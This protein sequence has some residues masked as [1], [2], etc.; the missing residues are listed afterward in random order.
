LLIDNTATAHLPGP[1]NPGVCHLYL[2]EECHLYIALTYECHGSGVLENH[3][4]KTD[5][6]YYVKITIAE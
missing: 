5:K 3:R 1:Q 2:A 6:V 4:A